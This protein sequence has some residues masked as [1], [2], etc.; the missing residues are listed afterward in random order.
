MR[1][2]YDADQQ[3]YSARTG[4]PLAPRL[5]I[6]R[7]RALEDANDHLRLAN[8]QPS[9]PA[10]SPIQKALRTLAAIRANAKAGKYASDPNP[11]LAHNL[12]NSVLQTIRSLSPATWEKVRAA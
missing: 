12:E 3:A 1:A 6:S 4:E 11:M 7:Q 10:A 2:N 9:V 8:A 5:S